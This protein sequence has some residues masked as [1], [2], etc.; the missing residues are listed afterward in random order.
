MPGE[1]LGFELASFDIYNKP[2]KTKITQGE[3]WTALYMGLISLFF[4]K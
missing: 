2:L 4:Y 1:Y 3:S